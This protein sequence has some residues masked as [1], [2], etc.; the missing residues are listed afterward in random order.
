MQCQRVETKL[1]PP[2][3][4]VVD[5]FLRS[6]FE[7]RAL[8]SALDLRIVGDG[9]EPFTLAHVQ[10]RVHGETRSLRQLLDILTVAEVLEEGD[11][12]YRMTAPFREALRFRPL[13]EAKLD[14]ALHVAPDFL[15][16][17]TAFLVKPREFQARSRLFGL[18][19]YQ[20]AVEPTPE[21]ERLTAMWMRYTTELTRHEAGVLLRLHDFR[22]GQTLLDVGGNSGELVSQI[23][24]QAETLQ[25]T[26]F[27]LPAVCRQG[28]RHTAAQP[29]RDRIRF[30]P[31][32]L[33][34]DSLPGPVDTLVMKSFLHD[35]PAPLVPMILQKATAALA[36]GGTLV[37]FERARPNFREGLPRFGDLP[38][39]LFARHFRDPDEYLEVLATLPYVS[40]E[41]RFVNLDGPFFL[42]TATKAGN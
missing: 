18:F 37:L 9:A 22:A 25:A 34:I 33:R 40:A 38:M 21:G 28:I 42:L 30:V 41:V 15:E 39:F 27:D 5:R 11:L 29:T 14:L 36:P 7:V 32:D 20:H 2:A 16:G 26:V 4:L 31:G 19:N 8:R 3:Y 24:A 13:L 6:P 12:G 35:W 1:E 17:Y 23:C 10:A